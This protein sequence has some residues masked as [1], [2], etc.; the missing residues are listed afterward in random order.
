MRSVT[1]PEV[2]NDRAWA[3]FAETHIRV[4]GAAEPLLANVSAAFS[5]DETALLLCQCMHTVHSALCVAV[6]AQG[7]SL[8]EA[9]STAVDFE[10]SLQSAPNDGMRRPSRRSPAGQHVLRARAV[11]LLE[12]CAVSMRSA[13]CK[14]A[15]VVASDEAP[16]LALWAMPGLLPMPSAASRAATS[17]HMCAPCLHRRDCWAP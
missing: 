10:S 16:P 6:A 12:A 14:A 3:R 2:D 11:T 15:S 4:L 13:I 1:N 8:P 9:W 17:S 7:R 5:G